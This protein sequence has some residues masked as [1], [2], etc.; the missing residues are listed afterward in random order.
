MTRNQPVSAIRTLIMMTLLTG[1]V[2]PV[3]LTVVAQALFPRASHGSLIERQGIVVGSELIAQR[4]TDD[5]Y[6]WPR[7]SANDYNPI[8]SGGSNLG[9]TSKALRD[10]VR[11]RRAEFV[12]RNGLPAGTPVPEEMLTTSA[13]GVDPHITPLSALLQVDRVARARGFSDLQRAGLERL[14]RSLVEPRQFG[15][16]GEPRVNVLVLNLAVD[17]VE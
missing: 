9:P 12:S 17:G 1:F 6:F 3:V 4:F 8:P 11:Q 15:L 14:V 13:S 10:S 5:R 7:P 16:F 2:Y